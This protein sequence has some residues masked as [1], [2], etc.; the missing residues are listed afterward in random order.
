[1]IR[2]FLAIAI[3]T[4]SFW[5]GI[6]IFR[7]MTGAEKWKAIKTLFYAGMLSCISTLFLIAI[8]ILF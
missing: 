8:V 1:M 4:V 6:S 2:V 7:E 5:F 3:M